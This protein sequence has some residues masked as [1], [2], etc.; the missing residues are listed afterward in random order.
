MIKEF[1]SKAVTS[2]ELNVLVNNYKETFNNNLPSAFNTEELTSEQVE[3]LKVLIDLS[4]YYNVDLVSDVGYSKEYF[5]DELDDFEDWEDES[6]YKDS[7]DLDEPED[8]D[9]SLD[10]D[11]WSL[12]FE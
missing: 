10:C 5:S 1:K 9:V 3:K 11:I 7:D 4:L 12:V 8:N 2:I 6:D